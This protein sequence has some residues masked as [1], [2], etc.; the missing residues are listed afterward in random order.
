MAIQVYRVHLVN[1][2]DG[3]LTVEVKE[4]LSSQYHRGV[5][6]EH[7]HGVFLYKAGM[8]RQ[9]IFIPWVNVT[10]VDMEKEG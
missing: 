1:P 8:G 4:D 6:K 2:I 7:E 3:E 10:H 5:Y 9:I